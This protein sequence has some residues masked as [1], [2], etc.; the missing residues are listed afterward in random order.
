MYGIILVA[1]A[2]PLMIIYSNEPAYIHVY[3]VIAP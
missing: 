2:E 3:S 1:R